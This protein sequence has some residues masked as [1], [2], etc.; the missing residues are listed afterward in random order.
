MREDRLL[1]EMEMLFFFS[2]MGSLEKLG[3]YL[4]GTGHGVFDFG[5]IFDRRYRTDNQLGIM[6]VNKVWHGMAWHGMT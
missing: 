6:G 4:K 2:H 1:K 3:S 5:G